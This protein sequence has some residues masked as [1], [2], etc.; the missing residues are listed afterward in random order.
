MFFNPFALKTVKRSVVSAKWWIQIVFFCA[1]MCGLPWQAR[2]IAQNRTAALVALAY[3]KYN[4]G[5]FTAAKQQL[6]LFYDQQSSASQASIGKATQL[7]GIIA[8]SE[9]EFTEALSYYNRSLENYLALPD[10]AHVAD[11]LNNLGN[12]YYRMGQFARAFSY[13]KISLQISKRF[14]YTSGEGGCYNSL[15]NIYYSWG[16]YDYA[17]NAYIHALNAKRSLNDSNEICNILANIGSVYTGIGKYDSA[18]ITYKTA[19]SIALRRNDHVIATD[20]DINIAYVD[21]QTGNINEAISLLKQTYKFSS[22]EGYHLEE[23][24]S[25]DNL[26]RAYIAVD[27]F[28]SASVFW[29]KAMIL[30]REMNIPEVSLNL[31][32]TRIELLEKSNRIPEA[33][34]YSKRFYHQHDSLFDDA[35]IEQLIDFNTTEHIENKLNELQYRNL[36]LSMKAQEYRS[37]QRISILLIVI[38]IIV[39]ISFIVIYRSKEKTT[40]LKFEK[41]LHESTQ[42]A[43]AAQM[44][45]HFI[46]NSLNS[47]QKFF[48]TNDIDAASQYLNSFGNL[49]RNVLDCSMQPSITVSEEL[50]IL[51]LYVE[52]ESMRLGRP[53]ALML[54]NEEPD[55]KIPPLI[56]QPIV[57]NSIWHGLAK[58]ENSPEIQISFTRVEN[59]LICEI[60]DNGIGLTKAKALQ[61]NMARSQRKSYGLQL[62]RERL[63]LLMGKSQRNEPL[64]E[65]KEIVVEGNVVGTLTILKFPCE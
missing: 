49:I 25:L 29:D 37:I 31:M 38:L 43:L 17:L 39:I 8:E 48:M 62:V 53:I 52:L 63:Q 46:S 11:V 42:K 50:R 34:A 4:Q 36:A 54:I 7:S 3:E 13:T 6:H 18:R 41:Q 45:P 21:I 30:S 10:Y 51:K 47:I 12:I 33:Y 16:K 19:Q 27:R 58:S 61:T 64:L 15:G 20:C 28:D 32:E 57:E 22:K 60:S 5:D 55:M 65:S 14:K 56:L 1:L 2:L 9:G 24:M 23:L 44:N 40:K 35:S 26:A 59:E